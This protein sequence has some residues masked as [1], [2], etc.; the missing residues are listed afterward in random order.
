MQRHSTPVG[1]IITLPFEVHAVDQSWIIVYGH[2]FGVAYLFFVKFLNELAGNLKRYPS[3]SVEINWSDNCLSNGN[4]KL[5]AFLQF[6]RALC[7]PSW[8]RFGNICDKFL[9]ML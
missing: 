3:C 1:H 7:S 5:L 6:F 8:Q 9:E 4:I 2:N